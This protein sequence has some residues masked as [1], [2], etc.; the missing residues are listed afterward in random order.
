MPIKYTEFDTTNTKNTGGVT[1]SVRVQRSDGNYYQLK[2]SILSNSFLRR[3]KAGGVDRENFGEVIASK[4][5]REM[6]YPGYELVPDVTLTWN[7]DNKEVSVASKYL[8]G[9][10]VQT[11]DDYA[12]EKFEDFSG[13][14]QSK[15]HVKFT[16]NTTD[17]NNREFKI[18]GDEQKDLRKGLAR[19]LAVSILVGD[20]DVNPGNMMV[21]DGKVSR[22]DFGH[23]FNDLLNAPSLFGGRVRNKDNQVLDF[24]N[25]EKLANFLPPGQQPKLWRDYPGIVPTQEMVDSLKEMS[26][27]NGLRKGVDAARTEFKQLITDLRYDKDSNQA[28]KTCKHILDSLKEINRAIG[29]APIPSDMKLDESIDR[30]FDNI[31]NFCQKSQTQM[32][33]VSKLMQMQVDI[34]NM[35]EAKSKGVEVL[36][37]QIEAIKSQY[38]EMIEA[39]GIGNKNRKS[40][41]WVKTS[42]DEPA[43][44]GNLHDYIHHRSKHLSFSKNIDKDFIIDHFP[45]PEK[46]NWF[47]KF[48]DY[49]F[50]K[51]QVT[52]TTQHD[53]TESYSYKHEDKHVKYENTKVHDKVATEALQK[54]VQSGQVSGP[55]PETDHKKE[56]V[57][58]SKRTSRASEVLSPRKANEHEVNSRGL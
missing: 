52:K 24:F 10:K 35:L 41:T 22:I 55:D 46:K 26:E 8:K 15:N 4:I 49:F 48:I 6:L 58:Q 50:S 45:A 17:P 19:S 32:L 28:L 30:I 57:N 16:K 18:S 40:I 38:E 14:S 20:H 7:M 53:K 44:E 42:A 43:V 1:G 12:Q 47:R 11:L 5:T 21:V 9:S 25:R 13:V 54:E 29:A 31:S 56:S 23:A 3:L 2:P 33:D 51:E 34:D 39:V 36:Q 27:S 37:A